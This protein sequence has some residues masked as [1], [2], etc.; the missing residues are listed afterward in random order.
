[1]EKLYT[2][3]AAGTIK[4]GSWSM[5]YIIYGDNNTIY[6]Y[7]IIISYTCSPGEYDIL[8]SDRRIIY[9]ENSR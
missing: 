9:Y 3:A 1:M 4:T 6:V 2:A 7:Y 5:A 8:L